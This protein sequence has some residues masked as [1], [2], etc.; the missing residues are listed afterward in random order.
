MFSLNAGVQFLGKA[1]HIKIVCLQFSCKLF[2][3]K[4][5]SETVISDLSKLTEYVTRR[6]KVSISLDVFG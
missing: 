2:Q 3:L 6:K 5:S 4:L 1:Q